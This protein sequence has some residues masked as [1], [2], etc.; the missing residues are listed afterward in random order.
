MKLDRLLAITMALLN[1]KRISAAELSERFEVSLRTV[2]RDMETISQA[3]IPIVSFPGADGGYEIMAGYR[4]E[5]QL[6][7]LDDFSSICAALRGYRAMT[8]N[9]DIE[10]L[11]EKIGALNPGSLS[12]TERSSMEI[13]YTVSSRDKEKIRLLNA[14]IRDLRLVAFEYIDRNGAETARVVEPHGIFLKGYSWYMFGYCRTR[15]DARVFKLSRMIKLDTRLET[16]VQRP[17]TLRDMEREFKDKISFTSFETRLRFDSSVK[18]R[19]R[20]EF[21]IED[22]AAPPG[23][24]IEVTGRYPSLASAVRH[25]LSFGAS[26]QTIAPP[27]LIS[28]VTR[29]IEAM[30]ELYRRADEKEPT[31]RF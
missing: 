5:K 1:Q 18:T 27:E 11:I 10:G 30:A 24:P 14:A 12:N 4:L 19:V 8:D 29:Q 31:S 9:E 15:L 28:E 26:V 25:V 3:G 2:Y 7:S 17:I 23:G 16:F 21:P 22:I 6:L 20:D 13:S